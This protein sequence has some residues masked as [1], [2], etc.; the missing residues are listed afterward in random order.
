[1]LRL[2]HLLLIFTGSGP[3]RQNTYHSNFSS[4]DKEA[5]NLKWKSLYQEIKQLYKDLALARDNFN[6]NKKIMILNLIEEK[7]KQMKMYQ[8]ISSQQY[9]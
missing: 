2:A 5:E 1:M 4:M 3:D 7:Q 6:R 8:T 9:R